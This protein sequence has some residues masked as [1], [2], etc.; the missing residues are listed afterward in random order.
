MSGRGAE[1]NERN[2]LRLWVRWHS[3]PYRMHCTLNSTCRASPIGP[4][5]SEGRKALCV[6]S[7]FS[8]RSVKVIAGIRQAFRANG[9]LAN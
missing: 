1:E 3:A 8:Y 2:F 7:P 5:K 9:R 4:R 6:L